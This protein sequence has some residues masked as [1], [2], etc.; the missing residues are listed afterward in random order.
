MAPQHER[1]SLRCSSENIT[2][3]GSS[4]SFLVV[5]GLIGVKIVDLRGPVDVTVESI[6]LRRISFL[7]CC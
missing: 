6:R 3:P 4:Y 5:I 7:I 1:Q 2:V